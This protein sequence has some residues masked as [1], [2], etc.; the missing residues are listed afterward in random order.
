M[1]AVGRAGAAGRKSATVKKLHKKREYRANLA[2]RYG[3]ES[4]KKLAEKP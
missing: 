2:W 1:E 4:Q 3:P